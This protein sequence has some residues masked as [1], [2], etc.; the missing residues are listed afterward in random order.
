[1]AASSPAPPD[2]RTGRRLG[3]T[4]PE[5][6]VTPLVDVVL[7]LLII[8]MVVAPQLEHGEHV[9]LPVVRRPDETPKAKLDPI[10]VTVTAAGKL[11]LEREPIASTDELRSRLAAVRERHPERR[12]LVKGDAAA[13]YGR[14]RDAFAACREA[15]VAGVS[16]S[17]GERSDRPEAKGHERRVAH[18]DEAR[19]RI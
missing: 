15:G 10:A 3:A 13:P 5:I 2:A 18:G 12:V 8:F 14:V 7:V 17:V 6:N 16:L 4:A 11:F 9:D 19:G 1:M